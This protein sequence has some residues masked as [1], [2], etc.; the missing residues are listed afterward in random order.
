MFKTRLAI[1]S[2]FKMMKRFAI[3]KGIFLTRDGNRK[4]LLR[5]YL[6]YVMSNAKAISHPA[7]KIV[8]LRGLESIQGRV[9]KG[10]SKVLLC[11][12]TDFR[13]KL[14]INQRQFFI[15][16]SC[17]WS[18]CFFR[19]RDTQLKKPIELSIWLNTRKNFW[20]Y[21]WMKMGNCS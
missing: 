8:H 15:R 16:L 13:W 4:Q 3:S 9:L 2:A 17:P 11:G 12:I 10:K 18:S 7:E 6:L 19:K 21:L 1:Y 14:C 20:I 5:Q